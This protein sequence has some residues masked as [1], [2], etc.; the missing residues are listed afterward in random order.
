M[1]PYRLLADAVLL[2]HFGVVVFVVAGL[3]AIVVGNLR[4]WRWV[5]GLWFRLVHLG[6]IGVVIGALGF[7]TRGNQFLADQVAAFQDQRDGLFLDRGWLF[8]AELS[9]RCH[10]GLGQAKFVEIGQFKYLSGRQTR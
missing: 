4:G 7:T 8:V 10:D 1:L 3:A 9:Q 5:N 6:A 2:L